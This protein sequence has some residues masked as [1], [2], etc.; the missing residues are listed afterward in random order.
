[1]IDNERT[2]RAVKD[3]LLARIGRAREKPGLLEER[4]VDRGRLRPT[5]A[6]MRYALEYADRLLRLGRTTH[7][8]A[9]EKVPP[10]QRPAIERIV[11]DELLAGGW[12]GHVAERIEELVDSE[13]A[14]VV[15][16]AAA[17]S[18]T[19]TGRSSSAMRTPPPTTPA[20]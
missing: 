15:P 8:A 2:K 19:M 9:A 6:G 17:P 4:L 11:R 16:I 20:A 7:T 3:T 5:G 10:A 13:P 14:D 12:P 1:M 18:S